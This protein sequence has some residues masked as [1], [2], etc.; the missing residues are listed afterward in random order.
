VNAVP[1]TVGAVADNGGAAG[2]TLKSAPVWVDVSF[3]PG[4][5]GANEVH[6]TALTPAGA[7]L[8]VEELTV[9]IDLPRR[10]IAPITVPLRR[11]S[12]GHYL[13]P[14]F[15]VPYPGEWRVTAK[16]RLTEFDQ[17]TLVGTVT[18]AARGQV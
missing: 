4:R 10:R 6:A 8:N 7:P 13:S 1:G 18:I 5:S 16:P 17:P 15:V 12:P 14:G 11:L 2:I 3:T 9:T